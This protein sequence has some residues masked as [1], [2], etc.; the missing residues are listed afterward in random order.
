MKK[1]DKN[2]LYLFSISEPSE[3]GFE[4]RHAKKYAKFQAKKAILARLNKIKDKRK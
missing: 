3:L 4:S 2:Q 1:K